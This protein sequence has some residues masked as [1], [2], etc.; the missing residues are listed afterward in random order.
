MNYNSEISSEIDSLDFCKAKLMENCK[1]IQV[2]DCFYWANDH[3]AVVTLQ[4]QEE[5][6]GIP[7]G[8]KLPTTQEEI[9]RF[10][11]LYAKNS[12]AQLNYCTEFW[13]I[14]KKNALE[15]FFA[16]TNVT[17]MSSWLQTIRQFIGLMI[18][19]PNIVFKIRILKSYFEIWSK[20][21][22]KIE[23]CTGVQAVLIYI[24]EIK[25]SL[26]DLLDEVNR[27]RK[28]IQGIDF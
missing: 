7:T 1:I 21:I 28:L 19:N 3:D 8:L 6:L 12:S 10:Y 2:N 13:L 20:V 24:Q 9:D 11:E 26:R 18:Q 4:E 15:L 23:S 14:Q 22:K 17:D 25:A 16:F 5:K 27:E